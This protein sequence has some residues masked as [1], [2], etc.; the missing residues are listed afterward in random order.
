MT[1]GKV[2][3]CSLQYAE[4]VRN[5]QIPDALDLGLYYSE[6]KEQLQVAKVREAD[7]GTHCYVVGATGTGK[8]KFL[9]FLIWQD[10]LN[11]H[12]F[13]VI[14]PHGDLVEDIKGL[15]AGRYWMEDDVETITER[16][17]L[18]DPTDYEYTVT[19]NP[20]ESIPGVSVAEQAGELVSSFRKIWSDSWGARMEDLMRNTLI[21][22]GEAA[23]TL[24]E[25]PLFLTRRQFRKATMERVQNPV[26]IDYF[27]RFD[28]L[29]DR[30]QITWIEPVMN[31][32]NAFLADERT[33]LM[34]ASPRSSFN[35][36]E[37]MDEGKHLLIKLDKGKL[38]GAADLLGSLFMAK[39]QMAAF[40]RSNLQ[41][42]ERVPF[43]LYID[44]F[45]NF[46]TESFE[47]ILSEARKYGLSLVMAH[48]SLSQIPDSLRGLI[49]SSAGLQVFF[50]LNRSDASLLAKEIFQYSGFEVK[51][52]GVKSPVYWSYAEEWE[53]K[54]AELQHLPPRVC[55]LKHKIQGAVAELNTVYVP[56]PWECLSVRENQCR[57]YMSIIPFG[58]SYLEEKAELAERAS[59]RLRDAE[60]GMQ[61]EVEPEPPA[62]REPAVAATVGPPGLP[63]GAIEQHTPKE[64]ASPVILDAAHI[65]PA[66]TPA[67]REHRRLQHLIKK[68][69]E[70]NGYRATIEQPTADGKG[71]VDIGL[72]SDDRRI[73]CEIT[74]TTSP[75]H[76]LQ[77]IR[78]C[79]ASGYDLVILFASER[80]PLE[81]VKT[82]CL[83]ELSES[84]RQQVTFL[85]PDGLVMFFEQEAANAASK[86]RKVKGYTVKVDYQ[87]LQETEKHMKRQALA[88]IVFKSFRRD[89]ENG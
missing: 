58:F 34:F 51:S 8:T 78:K 16:V 84:E 74:V 37:I 13:G 10:I 27:H 19:F 32:I 56:A 26:A 17:V 82:L 30:A 68:L 12:G 41:P 40:S 69:A 31:K 89:K 25:L 1:A 39:I 81:K 65:V 55:Y 20:L 61:L 45:Q 67:E 43:Y 33:R 64:P 14:D 29:T 24:L 47:V 86:T 62:R 52:E 79:L 70:Q 38:R 28:G 80:K 63:A 77:N 85:E 88:N 71:R 4:D 36:R 54:I 44:E 46:A 60:A 35:L 21:A 59:E 53:H 49:L 66:D 76:E 42:S 18:I 11:G 3:G 73:A 7:R 2:K 22:L 5:E 87:P 9:E 6:N 75:E 15:L 83:E 23:L 57:H 72:E 50:R 48:Q